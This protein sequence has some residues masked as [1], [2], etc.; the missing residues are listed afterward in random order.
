MPPKRKTTGGEKKD[1]KRA[2]KAPT[3]EEVPPSSLSISS[4]ESERNE[5]CWGFPATAKDND[6][7]DR[8]NDNTQFAPTFYN[9]EWNTLTTREAPFGFPRLRTPVYKTPS[10]H[11]YT[12]LGNNASQT[13]QA[14]LDLF[15]LIKRNTPQQKGDAAQQ[16]RPYSRPTFDQAFG[17]DEDDF[18]VVASRSDAHHVLGL[19]QD[20]RLQV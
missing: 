18:A 16:Q 4:D 19:A 17:N 8:S 12:P 1:S 20:Y 6:A 10:A 11:V 2:K 13:S 9:Q 3:P 5:V 15:N 14:V 7:P